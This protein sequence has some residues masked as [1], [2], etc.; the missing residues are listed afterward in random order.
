MWIWWWMEMTSWVDE[1]IRWGNTAE[2]EWRNKNI[3]Y[4]RLYGMPSV[5]WHCW[6]G[7]RKGI[8]SVK[9][10]GGVLVWLSVW[11]KVETC[12][13][14]S[15][16]HCH[17]LSLASVKSRLV[18]PFWYRLTWVVLEKGPLNRCVCVWY[19]FPWSNTVLT[20]VFPELNTLL[21]TTLAAYLLCFYCILWLFH[22]NALCIIRLYWI[23]AWIPLWEGAILGIYFGMHSHCIAAV[24][25]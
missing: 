3:N 21:Q 16:C 13:W 14:P 9:N 6:L 24:D 12:I 22:Q 15:W 2:C 7:A 10:S 25:Q 18:L 17:S 19:V 5:L 23:G 8:R 20:L 11:S 1:I 4:R